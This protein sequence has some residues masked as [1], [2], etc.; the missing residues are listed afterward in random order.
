MLIRSAAL[1]V[2]VG[3]ALADEI[4]QQLRDVYAVHDKE[5]LLNGDRRRRRVVILVT[6]AGGRSRELLP[7]PLR[8]ALLAPLGPGVAAEVRRADAAASAQDLAALPARR[9]GRSAGGVAVSCEATPH[10][11][12]ERLPPRGR[13]FFVACQAERL[14]HCL[15]A[16]RER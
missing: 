13:R 12:L 6:A 4:V 16:R 11:G 1:L 14:M 8:G 3:Q 7:P 10:G 5:L 2:D 9:G 15:L